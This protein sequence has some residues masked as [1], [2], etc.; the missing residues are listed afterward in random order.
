[1]DDNPYQRPDTFSEPRVSRV[2]IATYVMSGLITL[3]VAGSLIVQM[4]SGPIPLPP[5][6]GAAPPPR[7][8]A[9]Q[10]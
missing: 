1:M 6:G 10:P 3:I 2:R 4:L 8:P 7:P 9:V 5:P